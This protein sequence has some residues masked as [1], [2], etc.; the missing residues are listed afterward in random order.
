MDVETRW[1]STYLTLDAALQLRKAFDLLKR[2]KNYRDKIEKL[3]GMPTDDDWDYI[4]V[5]VPF[6]ESFYETTLIIFA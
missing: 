3:K 2:Y 4:R 5:L 1:N 6:L